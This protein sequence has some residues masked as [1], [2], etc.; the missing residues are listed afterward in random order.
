LVLSLVFGP[1]P[2]DAHR[3][4]GER[5]VELP[6]PQPVALSRFRLPL[7]ASHDFGVCEKSDGERCMLLLVAPPHAAP[8]PP[9]GAYLLDRSFA[10]RAL[11]GG[12]E[13]GA[14]LAKAGGPTLLDGELLQREDDMGSGTGARAV[15]MVFDCI[16]ARGADVAGKGLPERLQA[17][18]SAVREPFRVLDETPRAQGL[19][20]YLLGKTVV[21][22]ADVGGLL[23]KMAREGGAGAGGGD[24]QHRI[25]R[26]GKRVNAT[27]GLIF[28]PANVSYRELLLG[29]A[30]AAVPIVKWKFLDEVTVDFKLKLAD[31]ERVA[32]TGMARGRGGGGGGSGG[33]GGGGGGGG[34]SAGSADAPPPAAPVRVP[35]YLVLGQSD[36]E[37]SACLLSPAE[38]AALVSTADG[39]GRDDFLIA[40]CA[41]EAHCSAWRI[42]RLRLDKNRANALRTG[43]STLEN[44]VE[45]I[46]EAEVV[47]VCGGGR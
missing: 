33:G 44:L 10:V 13:Y 29:G 9:P 41:F 34:S 25:Y 28:T 17:L 37:T 11:D 3:F 46:G 5:A 42:R 14:A 38:A 15:Y 20:L 21:K 1:A 32:T 23:A 22:K 2:Y 39:A 18:S 30:G 47:R 43:W 35:L 8:H 40:E 6:G 16:T 26:D 31:L 27:D 7:L 4:S 12:A 36:L 24:K 19:P 45:N